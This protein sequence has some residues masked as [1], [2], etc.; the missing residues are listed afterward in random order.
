MDEKKPASSWDDLLK[1]IGA[2]PPPDALERK[3]PAIETTFEPPPEVDVSAVKPKPGDWNALA[4]ELGVEVREE[5]A[6]KT[7]ERAQPGPSSKSLE[8][9]LAEIEPLESSFETF[10]EEEISDVEFEGEEGEAEEEEAFPTAPSPKATD[11]NA[12]SGEAARSAFEALFEAGSFAALPPLKKPA[13]REPERKRQGPQW[14]EP[15][16]ATQAAPDEEIKFEEID[17]FGNVVSG[18]TEELEEGE[19]RRPRRR[20]RRRRGRGREAARGEVGE[21]RQPRRQEPDEFEEDRA[22]PREAEE[23]GAEEEEGEVE[24]IGEEGERPAR[25]RR[26][27][28]RGGRARDAEEPVASRADANGESLQAEEDEEEELE[29]AHAGGREDEDEGDES[30]RDSHKNIPTWSEAISVMVETNLQSRKTS[31]SRPSG[32]RERGRGGRGRGRGGS[33]RRGKS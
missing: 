11:P 8:A 26:R 4:S 14:R 21:E 17:E 28:R 1:Q 18:E 19:E 22:A 12:L 33:G 5:P 32:A 25:R 27:R 3:R 2:A 23:E 6:R 15:E 13:P 31:P 9:I 20:R 29:A 10:V 7:E 16:E 30:V 24:A